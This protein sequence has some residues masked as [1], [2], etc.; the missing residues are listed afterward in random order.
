M[1]EATVTWASFVV[2]PPRGILAAAQLCIDGLSDDVQPS[3][4]LGDKRV[5]PLRDALRQRQRYPNWK[6]LFP[7]HT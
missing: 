3:L 2:T 4:T 7:A 5:Y 6:F 1:T